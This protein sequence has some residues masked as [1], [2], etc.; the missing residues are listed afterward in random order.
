MLVLLA[1]AGSVLLDYHLGR[2]CLNAD[3][4]SEMVLANQLNKEG[5]F[6]SGNW[7][8]STE[9][10]ILGQAILFKLTLLLFPNNWLLARTAAQAVLL[11]LTALSYIYMASVFVGIRKSVLFSTILMCPFG[12]W[13]MYHGTFD[14][15]YL[16]WIAAYTF[17]AGLV[18]RVSLRQGRGKVQSLRWLLLIVVSFVIGLQ[19]VRGFMNLQLPLLAA[20]LIAVYTGTKK[21]MHFCFSCNQTEGKFLQASL[22]SNIAAFIGYGINVGILSRIY[23]YADQNDKVWQEFSFEKMLYVLEQFLQIFGYPYD[24]TGERK[25]SLFSMNGL[26]GCFGLLFIFLVVIAFIRSVSN[27]SGMSS[28]ERI[29]VMTGIMAVVIPALIFTFFT[30]QTNGSYFLPGVGLVLVVL[31]LAVDRYPYRFIG[32]EHLLTGAILATVA[33]CSVNTVSLYMQ[34]P[35]TAY[36]QMTVIA[37][38]LVKEDY[39]N[40]V[41]TFWYGNTLTE[42]S[43]GKIEIWEIEDYST[44]EVSQWLQ[45]KDHVENLPE[46]KTALI[47]ENK[48]SDY[49]DELMQ[50]D[51]ATVLYEDSDL[52]VI[53]IEDGQEC[54]SLVD[55]D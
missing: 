18:F 15:F 28:Q 20:S 7:F 39:T 32:G 10:R 14:G 40:G 29:L 46:G 4:A 9:I 54:F 35:P 48:Y 41:A 21:G 13:Y 27:Y 2:S 25:I 55:A 8:Y 31:Q 26:L 22:A 36:E 19:S 11:M 1:W 23:S 5:V 43:S 12:F 33:A 24:H 53:G 34:E 30:E 42:L 37:D 45:S 17:C 47:V 38:L 44:M 51:G 6:L 3:M 49:C 50:C 16:I 52:T